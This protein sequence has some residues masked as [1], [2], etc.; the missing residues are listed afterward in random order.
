MELKKLLARAV[1]A[2]QLVVA[3]FIVSAATTSQ[4][5]VTTSTYTEKSIEKQA[6]VAWLQ[7]HAE[8][9]N[10][11]LIGEFDRVGDVT[12][13]YSRE[14][15]A[16]RAYPQSPG[17]GPPVPLPASGRPG[18]T[19]SVSSCSRGTNQTW[20]YTWVSNSAGGTWVLTS[21]KYNQMA[22]GSGSGGA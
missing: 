20:S 17:D 12:V 2:A 21:Y 1:V 15:E 19:I 18:D 11:K 10:G 6:V 4:F 5:V 16:G 7:Q 13:T 8:H 3:P 22:C 14:T 9:V